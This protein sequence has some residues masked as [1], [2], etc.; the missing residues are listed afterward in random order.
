MFLG[1]NTLNV[2]AK[3][4]LAIPVKHR[5]AL[6]ECCASRVT[7]TINPISKARCLWLFPD[8]EWRKVAL[9]LAELP[10]M[11]GRSQA[12]KRL[13]L[14]NA[15][16]IEIDAQGRILLSAEQRRYAGLGKRVALVGQVNKFEIWDEQAWQGNLDNWLD[17]V[18]D[19]TSGSTAQLDGI[20][21]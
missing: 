9:K 14:G 10:A 15:S 6:A 7:V 13:L 12:L 1:V 2:D 5:D 21:L 17:Q 16:E 11:H 19:D 8:D 4:R 3:G 20:T 18:A